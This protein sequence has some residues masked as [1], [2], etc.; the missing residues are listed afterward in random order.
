[1]CP[2]ILVEAF[3]KSGVYPIN[4][5]QISYDQ[6]RPSV[7]YAGVSTISAPAGRPIAPSVFTAEEA[8]LTLTSLFGYTPPVTQQTVPL[9][10][11]N[12]STSGYT[13]NCAIVPLQQ[14][15][16]LFTY[17]DRPIQ[18]SDGPISAA[19]FGP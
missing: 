13:T 8:A 1:M 9:I 19:F 14:Q 10:R 6:A 15:G 7:V 11:H 4:R 18:Q 16:A 12:E 2:S 5:L 17:L 3:R